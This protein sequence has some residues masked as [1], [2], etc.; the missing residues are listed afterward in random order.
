M[1][2]SSIIGLMIG[3][4]FIFLGIVGTGFDVENIRI[5]LNLQSVFITF[6][7]ML[8]AFFISIPM[9]NIVT[10]WRVAVRAFFY[11]L[12]DPNAIVNRM[13]AY[14]E[15]AR[16]D[17]IL[18]LEGATSKDD[19]EFLV[20]G[21]QLAVDGTAP[22]LIEDIMSTDIEK[23]AARHAAGRRI[24]ETLAKYAPP[25]GMIGTLIGL[26]IML[27]NLDDPSRIGPGM[28]LALITTL[29]GAVAANFVFAPM[30][31]KLAERSEQ[32]LLTKEIIMR[33]VMAIQSGDNPRI[34]RQK[35][36]IYLAPGTRRGED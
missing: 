8:A 19:E 7:G 5:F 18:A 27:I 1:D 15:I 3:V 29:Y 14:A 9:G 16:R 31:G 20:R 25:W 2:I 34:V 32:E 11:V 6:G 4:F 24:F 26:I 23:L 28:A 12:P 22:E 36:R 21:I 10:A 33:G 13:V 35:L 30:A 17:G